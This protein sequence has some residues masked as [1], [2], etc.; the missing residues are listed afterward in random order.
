MTLETL[1]LSGIELK[2]QFGS[3]RNLST[4]IRP[5]DWSNRLHL[6]NFPNLQDSI[7]VKADGVERLVH[8]AQEGN[9]IVTDLNSDRLHEAFANN[10]DLEALVPI[11]I[12]RE[13]LEH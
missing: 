9:D 1:I 2:L 4:R 11:R 12:D 5:R 8:L 3:T 6:S 7:Q 10:T 13:C